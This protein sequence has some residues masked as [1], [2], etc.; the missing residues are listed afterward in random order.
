[1]FGFVHLTETTSGSWST[2]ACEGPAHGWEP[3]RDHDGEPTSC[4]SIVAPASWCDA[5][6]VEHADDYAT[7]DGT[8]PHV[9]VEGGRLR[10]ATGEATRDAIR[11]WVAA[12]CPAA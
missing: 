4:D 10:A 2:G 7:D 8:T 12:G 3:A 6:L 11:A 5:W 9:L 1:M